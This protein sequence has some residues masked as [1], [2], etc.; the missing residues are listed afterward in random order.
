LDHYVVHR[1][2]RVPLT[3]RAKQLIRKAKGAYLGTALPCN[4]AV[5]GHSTLDLLVI[6]RR[7]SWAGGYTV[8]WG[9]SHSARAR[10]RLARDLRAIEL[11]LGAHVG[12]CTGQHVETVTVGLIDGAANSV[13]GDDLTIALTEIEDHF[14]LRS[15]AS[16]DE[17]RGGYR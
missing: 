6:D 3:L 15:N 16:T 9:E 5:V 10:R 14:D 4:D 7:N 8:C 13:D 1:N 17:F 11:V 2:V 12:C